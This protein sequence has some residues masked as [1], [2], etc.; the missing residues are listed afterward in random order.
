MPSEPEII[1]RECESPDYEQRMDEACQLVAEMLSQRWIKDV[2]PAPKEKKY[3]T[4]D[5]LSEYLPVSKSTIYSW[6]HMK[7]IPYYKLGAQVRFDKD[8]VKTWLKKER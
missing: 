7:Q 4:V 8:K 6:T 5:E 3:M 2:K 1:I